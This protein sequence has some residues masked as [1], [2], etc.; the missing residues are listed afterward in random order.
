MRIGRR[1]DLNPVVGGEVSQSGKRGD[2]FFGARDGQ[3]SGW[4]EKIQLRVDIEK[5]RHPLII[6]RVGTRGEDLRQWRAGAG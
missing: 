5:N 1:D 4:V 6:V 3:R 2:D